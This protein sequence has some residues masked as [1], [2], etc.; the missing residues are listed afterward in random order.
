M[1][2]PIILEKE[3]NNSATNNFLNLFSIFILYLLIHKYVLQDVFQYFQDNTTIKYFNIISRIISVFL[4]LL[5]M[6]AGYSISKGHVHS[7]DD[8]IKISIYFFTIILSVFGI[9]GLNILFNHNKYLFYALFVGIGISLFSFTFLTNTNERVQ[10]SIRFIGFL[11]MTLVILGAIGYGIY[12]SYQNYPTYTILSV[13]L[14][15]LF[16]TG[17]TLYY[18]INILNISYIINTIQNTIN[19]I[20][21][22]YKTTPDSSKLFILF[23]I[24]ILVLYFTF[25]MIMNSIV[26][27]NYPKGKYL[28]SESRPLNKATIIANY[29]ELK[30]YFNTNKSSGKTSQY[31]YSYAISMWFQINSESNI[32]SFINLFNYGKNPAIEYAPSNNELRILVRSNNEKSNISHRQIYITKDLLYQRWNHV[33][34]NY[35]NA[36]L[37]IFMNNELVHSEDNILPYMEEDSMFIGSNNNTNGNIKDI[38]YFKKPLALSAIQKIYYESENTYNKPLLMNPSI[39]QTLIGKVKSGHKNFDETIQEKIN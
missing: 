37:D 35:H 19:D 1:A 6:F 32:D 27:V 13:T 9:L 17:Y 20:I 26:K 14:L 7:N 25:H 22:D 16:V 2:T 8:T 12:S 5:A 30:P 24:S 29:N 21:Q 38:I 34:L 4:F 3:D 11:L 39:I 10:K 18:G 23:Q 15:L 28:L 31:D 33:V 36:K